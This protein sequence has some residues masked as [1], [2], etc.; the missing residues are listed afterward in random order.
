MFGQATLEIPA[1]GSIGHSFH[2]GLSDEL[3]MIMGRTVANTLSEQDGS[4][5]VTLSNG[6]RK[7]IGHDVISDILAIGR[8]NRGQ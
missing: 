1:S 5:V 7:V 4:V 6:E 3:A 8:L 2:G